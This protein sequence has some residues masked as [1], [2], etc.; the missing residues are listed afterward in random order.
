MTDRARGMETEEAVEFGKVFCMRIFYGTATGSWEY[1]HA[2]TR[3]EVGDE[4]E[5]IWASKVDSVK[6]FWNGDSK[7]HCA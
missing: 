6:L 7:S 4:E 3:R 1:L 2:D 5:R